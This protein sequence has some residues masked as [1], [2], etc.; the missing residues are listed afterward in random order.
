MP[1]RSR[2]KKFIM[3]WLILF[4]SF[5]CAKLLFNLWAYGWIDLRVNAFL[6]T[7]LLPCAQSLVVWYA[8]KFDRR[9]D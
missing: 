6:E 2:C 5:A 4:V 3:L 9:I 8:F 1:T 7:L